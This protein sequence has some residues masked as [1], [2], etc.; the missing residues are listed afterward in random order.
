MI[1]DDWLQAADR[2][3][4]E[5]GIPWSSSCLMVV[6]SDSGEGRGSISKRFVCKSILIPAAVMAVQLVVEIGVIDMDLIRTDT[7]DGTCNGL[8]MSSRGIF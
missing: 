4:G 1:F 3:L 2:I 7:D 6:M 5:E 8:V